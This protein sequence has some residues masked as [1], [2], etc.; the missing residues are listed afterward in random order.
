MP[1]SDACCF[2][3][4]DVEWRRVAGVLVVRNFLCPDVYQHVL[5]DAEESHRFE[6]G[7]LWEE[8][9]GSSFPGVRFEY[10][11]EHAP[12]YAAGEYLKAR[13]GQDDDTLA[14]FK[15]GELFH[16][17]LDRLTT[18]R[19]ATPP[20]PLL[21]SHQPDCAKSAQIF[22]PSCVSPQS[23]RSSYQTRD[24]HSAI[25]HHDFEGEDQNSFVLNLALSTAYNDTAT[26]F[27]T[28]VGAPEQVRGACRG[29]RDAR[30]GADFERTLQRCYKWGQAGGRQREELLRN[31]ASAS[32]GLAVLQTHD[33]TGNFA[34]LDSVPFRANQLVVYRADQMHSAVIT[35]DACRRYADVGPGELQRGRLMHQVFYAPNPP[36]PV[37]GGIGSHVEPPDE[38]QKAEL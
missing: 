11:G 17:C 16:S 37:H 9:E 19:Q 25:I 28:P 12:E 10:V 36:R 31:F 7:R 18:R 38:K 4:A 23:V 22:A 21:T 14:A 33:P 30:D 26:A 1:R 24:A 8:R 32:E 5:A 29:T 3:A 34:F 2:T 6:R 20:W 13:G 15:S 27:W 35:P